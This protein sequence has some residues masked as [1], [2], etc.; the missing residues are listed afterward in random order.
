M[1]D[2]GTTTLEI[3][4]QLKNRSQ[5]TVITNSVPILACALEDFAGKI[6][7]PEAISI[8]RYKPRRGI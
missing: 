7:L 4:R 3:M 8:Q 1:L 6:I 5:I 2:N